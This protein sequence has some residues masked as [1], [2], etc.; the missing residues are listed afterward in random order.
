MIKQFNQPLLRL[1]KQNK[2]WVSRYSFFLK[3]FYISKMEDKLLGTL[4]LLSD[5]DH[6]SNQQHCQAMVVQNSSLYP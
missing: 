2:C 3:G 6:G 5:G 4:S 1:N